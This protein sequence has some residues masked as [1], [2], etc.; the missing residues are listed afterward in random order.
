MCSS[1]LESAGYNF[2]KNEINQYGVGNKYLHSPSITQISWREQNF[3][4]TLKKSRQ[5]CKTPPQKQKKRLERSSQR[6]WAGDT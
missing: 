5:M 4:K 1:I 3:R 6:V 2:A